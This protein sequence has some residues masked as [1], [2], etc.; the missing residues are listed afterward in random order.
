MVTGRESQ[1]KNHSTENVWK[2]TITQKFWVGGIMVFDMPEWEFSGK[3]LIRK[4]QEKEDCIFV[5]WFPINCDVNYMNVILTKNSTVSEKI[6]AY[7]QNT[8]CIKKKRNVIWHHECNKVRD[9]GLWLGNL[10]YFSRLAQF[11]ILKS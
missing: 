3:A 9:N 6:V 8:K 7:V 10:L 2:N 1:M 5:Q 4:P 11:L